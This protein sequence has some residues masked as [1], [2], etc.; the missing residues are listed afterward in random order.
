MNAYL[1][2]RWEEGA[3]ERY[4]L[5]SDREREITMLDQPSWLHVQYMC[6]SAAEGAA[7][8]TAYMQSTRF[9]TL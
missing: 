5:L 7:S 8:H 9:S 4:F 1:Q 3:M 6:L 2:P